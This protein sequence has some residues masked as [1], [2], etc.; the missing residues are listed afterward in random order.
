M[1]VFQQKIDNDRGF[2]LLVAKVKKQDRDGRTAEQIAANTG[3]S[4]EK[5]KDIIINTR[6]KILRRSGRYPWGDERNNKEK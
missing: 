6:S 5:I 1:M 4:V 3:E 2:A